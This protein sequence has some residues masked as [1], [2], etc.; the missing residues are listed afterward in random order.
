MK[1]FGF[2]ALGLAAALY[3]A[4]VIAQGQPDFSKIEG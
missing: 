1:Q 3:A 4:P 2:L